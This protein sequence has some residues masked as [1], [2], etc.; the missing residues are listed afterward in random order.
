MRATGFGVSLAALVMGIALTGCNGDEPQPDPTPIVASPT[1]SRS[2]SPT[3][4]DSATPEAESAKDFIR[5]F[6]AVQ[7]EA[8]VTGDVKE[9]RSL[10]RKCPPCM[11]LADRVEAIYADGGWI[12][13]DGWSIRKIERNTKDDYYIDVTSAPTK[14]R[15]SASAQV[16]SFEGGRR[17]HHIFLRETGDSWLVTEVLQVSS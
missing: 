11:S 12:K 13:T 10:Q 8:Q 1:E 16:K 2:A 9:Y 17:R 3:P 4:S 7:N 15:E 5:R 14:Y 6:V